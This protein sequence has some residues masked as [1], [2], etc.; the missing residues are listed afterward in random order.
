[1]ML[2]LRKSLSA[3]LGLCL[4]A[5]LVS[6]QILVA[7]WDFNDEPVTDPLVNTPFAFAPN[8]GAQPTAELSM[9]LADTGSPD[10]FGVR[11]EGTTIND[12]VNDPAEAGNSFSF[13]RGW[14]S[15]NATTSIA[16]DASSITD[17]QPVELS[18]AINRF[19]SEAVDQYQASYSLDG[20]D[21]F[22][23]IDSPVDIN[24]GVW[25]LHTIDFGTVLSG[26]SDAIVRLT[27]LGG[28]TN[29][30]PGHRTNLDNIALTAIP[31]PRVY[32]ALFGLLA[33]GF[34]VWRR[35]R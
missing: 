35:R 26:A 27:F 17:A 10:T 33:L 15:R 3:A 28:T 30:S 29:W 22:T 24:Q 19:A 31:E 9:V 13:G 21:N 12:I 16:F 25:E 8:A 18:F 6:G 34:V 2:N 11:N 7:F 5:S 1:M 23:N 32:A 14:R 20:G 4:G